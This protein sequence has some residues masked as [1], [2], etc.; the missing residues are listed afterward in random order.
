MWMHAKSIKTIER[1][2]GKA[3]IFILE[4]NDGFYEYRGEA[5]IVG[6]EYEGMYWSP[7]DHSGLFESASEAEGNA[8]DEVPWLR[9]LAGKSN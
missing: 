3:R 4:R 1:A 2:D 8:H 6:D 9:Q 7:T 5:E